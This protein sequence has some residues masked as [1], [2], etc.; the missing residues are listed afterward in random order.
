MR[1]I[2]LGADAPRDLSISMGYIGDPGGYAFNARN[3]VV[4]GMWEMDEWNLMHISPLPHYMTYA[5]FLLFGPGVAQMN[6]IPVIFSCLLL[7]LVYLLLARLT[8]KTFALIGVLLLGVNYQFTMFSRIAVRVVEMVFFVILA[9][10]L[11]TKKDAEKKPFAFLLAGMFC[12]V[13]FTVKG[14]FLLILPSMA[15]GILFYSFFQSKEKWKAVFS[16][17]LFFFLGMAAVFVLWLFLFYFPHREMFLAFGTENYNWLLPQNLAETLRNFWGRPLFFFLHM[18]VLTCLASLYLLVL[19][20]RIFAS[21]KRVS[22]LDWVCGLWIIFHMVYFSV[23]YYRPSRHFIPLILPIAFGAIHFLREFHKTEEIQKPGKTAFLFIPCLFFWLILPVQSVLILISRPVVPADMQSKSFILLVLALALTVV[24]F[25]VLKLWP[26]KLRIPLPHGLR[27]SVVCILV[28]I[29]LFVNGKAYLK[30]ALSPRYDVRT[31]SRDF[32]QAFGH[33]SLAGLLAPVISLENRHEAHPYYSG[34]INKGK[35]FI[36]KYQITHIFTTTYAEEKKHYEKDFP[37]VMAKARLLARYPLW[38]TFVELFEVNPPFREYADAGDVYEGETFFG[39]K[40]IPRYDPDAS[41]RFAYLA[42]QSKK[43]FF[44]ELA[45]LEYS[46]GYYKVL[47][48][49]KIEGTEKELGEQRLVRLDVVEKRRKDVFSY[50]DVLSRDV[51]PFGTYK[52]IA[53]EFQLRRDSRVSLRVYSTGLQ[54]VWIDKASV[55]RI[56]QK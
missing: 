54:R 4:F 56:E 23:I 33:M 18:P 19:G 16:P 39:V 37:E 42:E 5:V 47:F 32:G 15:V 40:S 41:C 46:L 22:L 25:L 7:V 44:I 31:I 17:L 36:D 14:T 3:K 29:S 11:L 48:R 45:D 10:Y 20:F 8:D 55:Q 53:L 12:F 21:P 28:L 51:E 27:T 6:L 49:L 30:W 34:Y 24:I 1:F 9:L 38:M 52:D 35:D 50:K 26:S 13:A 2:H 43:G